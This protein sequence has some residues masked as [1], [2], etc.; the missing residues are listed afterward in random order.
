MTNTTLVALNA[1]L[2]A[3]LDSMT[4]DGSNK[5]FLQCFDYA[6]PKPT[7]FPC[8]MVI[9]KD[10]AGEYD[11]LLSDTQYDQQSMNFIIRV[12]IRDNSDRDTYMQYIGLIDSALAELKKNDH[13]TLGGVCKFLKVDN[14]IVPIRS[15]DASEPVIGFDLSV[16]AMLEFDTMNP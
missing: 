12:L 2:K 3:I 11:G 16:S 1:A 10:G 8:A 9:F 7:Q 14:S 13:I 5:V 6:E 4:G 15:S